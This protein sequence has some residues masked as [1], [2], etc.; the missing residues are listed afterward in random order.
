MKDPRPV[1]GTP[2]VEDLEAEERR[3]VLPRADLATLHAL[4]HG[5][6]DAAEEERLP[7]AIQIR[8][9]DRLVFAAGAPGSTGLFDD[10]AARKARV[11]HLFEQSSLLVRLTHERDGVDFYAKHRLPGDRYAPFGGAFPIRVGN[12]G[13]IGSVAVSGL[14]QL[15]DHAFVVRKLGEFLDA[16]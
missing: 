16:S 2:L 7:L 6:Y 4:G 11:V 12:V 15:L 3:L 5:M 10:W 1:V 9:G 8:V 14:P 13:F